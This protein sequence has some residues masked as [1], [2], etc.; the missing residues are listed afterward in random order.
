MRVSFLVF[1][2]GP[3]WVGILEGQDDEGGLVVARHVF[4][5]EPTN[6]ELLAFMLHD[7]HRMR[8]TRTAL[9]GAPLH[10]EAAP[11]AKR[12]LRE[13]ARELASPPSSRSRAAL[14]AAHEAASASSKASRRD[15]K[16]A[17][18]ERRFSLRAAKRKER[19]R[20]R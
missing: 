3:F 18:A 2:E 20:G 5:A 7:F 16:A 19:H 1:F 13:A 15:A 10:E 9:P 4:G 11:G 14:A 8:R 17:E 12:A 6:P